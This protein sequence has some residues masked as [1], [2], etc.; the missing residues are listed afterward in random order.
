MAL[1]RRR[2]Q[3]AD[4]SALGRDVVAQRLDD[5]DVA[6]AMCPVVIFNAGGHARRVSAGKVN[7]EQGETVFCFHPGPYSVDLTPFAAAPEL[8]LRLRFVIDAAD[9]RVSQQRFDLFLYSEAEAGLALAVL[10]V[11]FEAALQTEL[12]QGALA[13]PPCTTLDEW[14]AFRAGLNQLLYTRFGVTVDDCVPVDLGDQVDYADMLTERALQAAAMAALV[15][16]APANADVGA[17]GSADGNNDRRTDG[18]ANGRAGGSVAAAQ[19]NRKAGPSA[20]L[21]PAQCDARSLRRLFLE[22]PA[23]MSAFRLV[24]LPAG[25]APFQAQQALLQRL[26]LLKLSVDTM[27]SLAWTAPDQPLAV[28]QQA[29]RS[30]NSTAAVAALDE[31]WALLARLQLAV[32]VQWGELFDDADRICANLEHDLALRRAP[33]E[34][35]HEDELADTHTDETVVGPA[36]S[37]RREPSL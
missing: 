14:H 36:A 11:Q 9:P 20:G 26:N 12:A 34:P 15:Q 17:E 28:D 1:F 2:R 31:A 24:D 3:P 30:R 25:P 16:S 37:N 13:L 33:Y 18:S 7:C 29:R 6:P 19:A 5:G 8:G 21:P 32:P 22:L 23:L 35:I 27:P 4:T 10:R